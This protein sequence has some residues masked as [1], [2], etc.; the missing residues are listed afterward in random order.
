MIFNSFWTQTNISFKFALNV[1]LYSYVLCNYYFF[2]LREI[3]TFI[4]KTKKLK[5]IVDLYRTFHLNGTLGSYIRYPFIFF[6]ELCF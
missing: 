1:Y 4:Y 5:F 3:Y 2:Y 6:K